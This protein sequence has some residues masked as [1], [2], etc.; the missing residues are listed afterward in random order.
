MWPN[1]NLIASSDRFEKMVERNPKTEQ[2]NAFGQ[3]LIEK[4][5]PLTSSRVSG[6]KVTQ[7]SQSNFKETN[8]L[9]VD[10]KK[11]FVPGQ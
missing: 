8:L 9:I 2:D 5:I 11:K 10:K 3:A 7:T 6:A 1:Y 4:E